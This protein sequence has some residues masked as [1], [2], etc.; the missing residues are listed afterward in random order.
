MSPF[1]AL[2]TPVNIPERV[3]PIWLFAVTWYPTSELKKKSEP[4]LQTIWQGKDWFIFTL[5]P[6]PSWLARRSAV[7]CFSLIWHYLS[8]FK[9][10]TF[11]WTV[12]ACS[13]LGKSVILYT[14]DLVVSGISTGSSMTCG[15]DSNK[16]VTTALCD[17]VN[18]TCSK[19]LKL[20]VIF[21]SYTTFALLHR[22]NLTPPPPT[23]PPL[24]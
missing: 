10:L 8:S 11:I 19:L 24:S 13:Q 22:A 7:F 5:S 12:W 4:A 18:N 16:C 20:C 21:A 6:W 23:S 9:A 17:S 1:P 3:F 14:L 2:R 15:N